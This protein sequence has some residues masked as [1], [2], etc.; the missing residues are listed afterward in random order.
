MP[1]AKQRTPELRERVL[2]VALAVLTTG[3]VGGFT[4]R[5]IAEAAATSVPAVYELFG[6]K[7]G[8]VREM[9][10]DG[11]RQLLRR[12]DRIVTSGDPRTDLA[13]VITTFR[14]FVRDEPVL[15][16][17][18]FSRPFA[19]FDP[20]PEDAQAGSAV[21]EFIVDHVARAVGAGQLHGDPTDIA[22]VLLA[23]AQGLAAQESAGWL[24]TTAAS[25]DRRWSL[26][27]TAVLDGLAAAHVGGTES[28]APR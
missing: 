23:T 5:K 8:L 27:V 15:A 12:L 4:T 6:D 19:D 10:F 2:Q 22:H 24:G 9:F 7:A 14:G 1:R 28:G 21:R 13:S 26:A 17:V 25:A 11:F 16:R 3:G 20:G 18:M